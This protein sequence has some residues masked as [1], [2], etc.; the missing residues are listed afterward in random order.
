M[1]ESIFE[2]MSRL[3]RETGA[4]NLGQGF[5]EWDGFLPVRQ[6]ASEA[7]LRQSNQY[8][9]SRG[10]AQLREAVCAYYGRAQDVALTPDQVLVTS[11]ATEAIASAIL[12]L[13]QTG[14]EVIVF[15]PLYDAYAPLI[16]RAGGTVVPVRLSPPDWAIDTVALNAAFS[17]K[18]KLVLI[19]TPNNPT[20]SVFSRSDLD[21]LAAL[22][23]AHNSF[24]LSDEVWELWTFT[25]T[26]QGVLS[27]P[28]LQ[29]RA[30]KVGSAG[31]LFG[32]TGWKV[33]WLCGPKSLID[34][35][36]Q[37]H[38]FVTFATPP[39][40]QNAVAYGLTL[41]EKAFEDEMAP[42]LA[43]RDFIIE[44]LTKAG[45]S[46]I[47]P[48]GTYFLNIDLKKSSI[49]LSASEVAL[50]LIKD[51]AVATIP[52]DAFTL[53]PEPMPVL[54]LCYA[55]RTD[56][57]QEGLKRLIVGLQQCRNVVS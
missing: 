52:L 51:F 24:V 48:L 45:L 47:S 57:L 20:T 37:I 26:H 17:A 18:T 34:Q 41:P 4:I 11:G 10:T 21:H 28:I 13:V 40:L 1:S 12:A 39:M 35:V 16:K 6:W 33:G 53:T 29:P 22:C 7:L 3:S 42:I 50:T 15:E 8:A 19:T 43:G 31:K 46:V 25:G 44:T 27:H 2:T 36:A 14:D 30:L 38:Q 9:P 55:K 5:P 54:R 56:T 32:L 49:A 23:E